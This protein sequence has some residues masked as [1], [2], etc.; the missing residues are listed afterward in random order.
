MYYSKGHG[1]TSSNFSAMAMSV[2]AEIIKAAT[3]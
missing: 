1:A 3:D 2:W